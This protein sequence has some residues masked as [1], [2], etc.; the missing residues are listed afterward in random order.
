MGLLL[1]LCNSPLPGTA[2]VAADRRDRMTA[3]HASR[4]APEGSI[5]RCMPCTRSRIAWTPSIP[6]SKHR[7]EPAGR[8]DSAWL[9]GEEV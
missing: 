4:D 7:P 9:I 5:C 6:L 1:T 2:K 8:M 3:N